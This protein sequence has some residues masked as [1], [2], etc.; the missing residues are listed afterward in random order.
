MNSDEADFKIKKKKGTR[1]KEKKKK[2]KDQENDTILSDGVSTANNKDAVG[3]IDLGNVSDIPQCCDSLDDKHNRNT[4]PRM[5]RSRSATGRSFKGLFKKSKNRSKST[6]G[7]EKEDKN[8]TLQ[9]HSEH[10][11]V[12]NVST[13]YKSF[14]PMLQP[15]ERLRYMTV[16]DAVQE[17]KSRKS[18]LNDEEYQSSNHSSS[19]P[20]L[21]SI[22]NTQSQDNISTVCKWRR[23]KRSKSADMPTSKCVRETSI[24][25]ENTSSENIGRDN[26]VYGQHD[27]NIQNNQITNS[28]TDMD[29]DLHHGELAKYIIPDVSDSGSKHNGDKAVPKS[30]ISMESP[31]TNSVLETESR[32]RESFS[33]FLNLRKTLPSSLARS[34]DNYTGGS[35]VLDHVQPIHIVKTIQSTVSTSHIHEKDLVSHISGSTSLSPTE[36]KELE[37][38]DKNSSI[39]QWLYTSMSEKFEK[40]SD[41]KQDILSTGVQ[42]DVVSEL[43][44]ESIAGSQFKSLPS[45]KRPS[46]SEF[47][48][49]RRFSGRGSSGNK[50]N[51]E[52]LKE[53]NHEHVI[54]DSTKVAENTPKETRTLTRGRQPFHNKA[55]YDKGTFAKPLV[56][57]TGTQAEINK[58]HDLT[59]RS[60]QT[61]LE[62]L[63]VKTTN[64]NILP[65]CVDTLKVDENIKKE[66]KLS[67]SA[68]SPPTDSI[69]D[70]TSDVEDPFK[71]PETSPLPRR[72]TLPALGD[73]Q[74]LHADVVN[75]DENPPSLKTVKSCVTFQDQDIGE[76][77]QDLNE[78]K[79]VKKNSFLTVANLKRRL[80]IERRRKTSSASTKSFK[81]SKKELKNDRECN[82]CPNT[83]SDNTKVF[84]E[85]E[86]NVS[87]SKLAFLQE[88]DLVGPM[89]TITDDPL[90]KKQISFSTNPDDG[91]LVSNE[92][93][94][95]DM[96]A[97][98]RLASRRESKILEKRRKV[99]SCCKSFIAF[100]FSHIGLSSLVVAYSI[101]GGV[102]FQALEAPHEK[103]LR[104]KV[105]NQRSFIGNEILRLALELELN[106][107][108]RDN[109]TNEVN[110]LLRSFQTDVYTAT[111]LHG[112]KNKDF[113]PDGSST[114]EDQ[115]S[116]ASSL[117]FAITVM[118]TIGK[119]YVISYLRTYA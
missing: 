85:N 93:L 116:F 101:L 1:K 28:Q 6:G 16:K 47:R 74:S 9:K 118:T 90:P 17:R 79:V 89:L 8:D 86:T 105:S 65:A 27:E 106:K 3:T 37:L 80:T 69:V 67:S 18:Y 99:I 109:F 108:S 51:K 81:K 24:L 59:S 88:T 41:E 62:S 78:A 115:W 43:D 73:I 98:R 19:L 42:T 31:H 56:F 11:H 95:D 4:L 38:V 102:I 103:E 57:S 75:D 14:D 32:Q 49:P 35:E 7:L 46:R 96:P 13:E 64:E 26:N 92:P 104:Y 76:K 53:E 111:E 97:R 113:N 2:Q 87:L 114:A 21:T 33:Q 25:Q 72:K 30:E 55:S 22:D 5:R 68:S 82:S 63:K 39:Q 58:A 117:L 52:G 110:V 100:L 91:P 70:L 50:K 48:S 84:L 23:P 54:M 12:D 44:S 34:G 71:T 40:G 66:R 10:N 119:L 94:G 107:R 61:S 36:D 15:R 83:P 77:D 60:M 45:K 112:F 29:K 20:D